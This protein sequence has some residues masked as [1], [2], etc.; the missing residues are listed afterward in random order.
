MRF[1]LYGG[2]AEEVAALKGFAERLGAGFVVHDWLLGEEPLLTVQC[3]PRRLDLVRS[4]EQ[5]TRWLDGGPIGE[6]AP[7]VQDSLPGLDTP[8]CR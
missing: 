4:I 1:S 2:S 3:F 5:V 7:G 6:G 8:P